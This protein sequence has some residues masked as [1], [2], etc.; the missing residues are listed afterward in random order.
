[1]AAV[2]AT[3]EAAFVKIYTSLTGNSLKKDGQ[4]WRLTTDEGTSYLPTAKDALRITHIGQNPQTRVL[5]KYQLEGFVE[6]EPGDFVVDVGSFIGE[7]ARESRNITGHVVA[8]EPDPINYAVCKMNLSDVPVCQIAA[9]S[10]TGQKPFNTATDTSES[11]ILGTD[12]A[13]VR[14]IEKVRTSRLDELFDERVNFVKI[15][16]EGAEPEVVQGM[17]GILPEKVAVECSPEREDDSPAEEVTDMLES[18]GYTVKEKEMIVF[19]SL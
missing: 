1:M 15:E 12:T 6:V 14:S 18:R 7:F 9:W 4:L 17:E 3:P 5:N 10:E 16:A 13:D 19:G 8:L 11:S 2:E